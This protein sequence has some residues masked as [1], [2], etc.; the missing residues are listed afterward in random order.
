MDARAV[1]QALEDARFDPRHE[2]LAHGDHSWAELTEWERIGQLLAVAAPGSV[3]DPDADAV[4]QAEL[5]ADAEA[6][7][8]QDARR[9]EAARIAARADELQ[10][11]RELG[12]LEEIEPCHGDEAV[13]DELTRRAGGHLQVDVD[14]WLAHALAGHLGHYRDSAAREAAV[15]LLPPAVLAHAALL[16]E[17]ARLILGT[18][19]DQL[20]F[21]GRLATTE[22]EA[23]DALATFLTRA[24]LEG[25]HDRDGT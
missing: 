10:A 7:A 14:G 17:L 24:R 2:V 11:L 6:S 19:A 13:R 21:A 12:T 22:P 18:H 9:R 25:R 8:A 1:R 15:S 3:Y 16:A 5:A 20:A 23:A 4:V